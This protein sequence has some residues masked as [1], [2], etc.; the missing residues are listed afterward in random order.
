MLYYGATGAQTTRLCTRGTGQVRLQ[1]TCR[2]QPTSMSNRVSYGA[3]QQSSESL[4]LDVEAWK[5]MWKK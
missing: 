4:H 2:K 1:G 3:I 5:W